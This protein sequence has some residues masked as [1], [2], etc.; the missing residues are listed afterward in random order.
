MK[1]TTKQFDQWVKE[2]VEMIPPKMSGKLGRLSFVVDDRPTLAFLKEADLKKGYA[3][4]GCY[5][6]YEQ[7]GRRIRAAVPDKV[8]IFRRAIID[9]YKTVRS[10]KRQV[11]KTVWHEISH[12]FG[13]DEEGAAKAERKMFERYENRF[14]KYRFQKREVK[15]SA[16]LRKIRRGYKRKSKITFRMEKV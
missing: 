3:L 5:Q 16:E 8:Y 1:I 7:T 6:G 13:S 14:R 11:M 15:K 4:F 9:Q 10:V 2:A 12:H